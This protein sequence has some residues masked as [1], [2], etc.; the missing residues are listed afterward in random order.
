M[1]E[2]RSR[3]D[4]IDGELVD[5]LALRAA[6]IDRAV[7]LKP[8]EGIPAR[9]EDRVAQVIDNVRALARDKALDPDL[10]EELWRIL[11]EWSIRREQRTID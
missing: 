1:A 2:L 8:G 10:A 4:R 9:A 7:Q 3:I 5:L 11:I 6:H